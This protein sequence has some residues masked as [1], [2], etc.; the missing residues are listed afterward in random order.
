MW[1]VDK[2]DL[3]PTTRET[4][5]NGET[6]TA[7]RRN[8]ASQAIAR[9]QRN[10]AKT[11]TKPRDDADTLADELV[12]VTNKNEATGTILLLTGS[13]ATVMLTY[14]GVSEPLSE[15][16][17]GILAKGQSLVFATTIGVFSGLGW[18]YSNSIFP[19]LTGRRLWAATIAGVSY[20]A[21]IACIDAPFNMQALGGGVAAQMSLAD[22]L[23]HYEERKQDLFATTTA[24]TRLAPATRVEAK[25]FAELSEREYKFGPNTGKPGP[26]KVTDGFRQVATLMGALGDQLDGGLA[27]SQAVMPEYT[28]A[29]GEM[30]S[31]VYRRGPIRER[32]EAASKAAD[33]LDE[34]TAQLTQLDYSASIR[35]TL[36]SLENIFPVSDQSGSAF[37]KVQNAELSVVAS[38]AK[39]VAGSLRSSLS[40]LKP[41]DPDT[42]KPARAEHSATAIYTYWKPL[43]PQWVAAIFVDI[44]PALLL[45]FLLAGRR[46]AEHLRRKSRNQGDR[47]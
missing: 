30:K 34:L 15:Q 16:G 44:A 13:A 21:L 17:G 39:T 11:E 37:E 47:P 4:A 41:L 23:K 22:A 14:F 9:I 28:A 36:T 26:G 40:E 7:R 33:R 2:K 38:M 43:W 25:R 42:L 24:A 35:A 12:E 45:V 18:I 19:R 6:D 1:N 31:H 20:L 27:K 29:L 5:K 3:P 8:N 46:E 10:R 32:T